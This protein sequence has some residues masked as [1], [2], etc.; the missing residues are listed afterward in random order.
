MLRSLLRFGAAI[1]LAALVAP[2]A[3]SAAPAPGLAYDEIVRVVV[4]ATPPP[5]GNFQTDLTTITSPAAIATPT[6]APKKRGIGIGAIAGAM[7]GGGGVGSIAGAVAGDAASNAMDN[8]MQASLGA[9]FATLGASIRGFL[10]PHLMHYAYY[11]GWE[12][13]DDVTADT[14]TIRKCDIGQVYKLDLA[15]KT[16]SVYDPASEPTP[17]AVAAPPARGQR[18]QPAGAPQP[19]GTA[20]ADVS[21]ITKSL[22]PLKIENQNTAGYDSTATFAMTQATGSCHNASASITTDE[23]FSALNRPAVTSCPIHRAPV[24]T[25]ATDIVTPQQTTT[26]GCKPTLTFHNGG[27]TLPANKL[28]LY[29]LVTMSG[30]GPSPAPAPAAATSPAPAGI[31]FLTERG[32]IKTLG[33]TDTTLFDVPAAFTK[34]P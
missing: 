12:R 2:I 24:P 16:Y 3:P 28:S 9:Q 4:G 30:G 20:V 26:G 7:L 14:A 21:A 18:P 32:N 29:T 22:G 1:A 17:A 25:S 23:Y 13:V 15:K 11:N 19:P 27:P 8:A 34:T 10:Q 33:A 6:P 5:P 31:A